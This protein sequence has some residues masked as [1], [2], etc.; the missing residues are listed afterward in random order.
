MLSP[1]TTVAAVALLALAVAPAFAAG[2][3]SCVFTDSGNGRSA[4]STYTLP[5]SEGWTCTYLKKT[6]VAQAC[7]KWGLRGITDHDCSD[8]AGNVVLEVL[9]NQPSDRNCAAP[10]LQEHW[11]PAG[12][13]MPVC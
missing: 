5:R 2:A 9:L 8:V 7:G 4:I 3:V 13:A 6:K 12:A 11:A 1:V 10:A